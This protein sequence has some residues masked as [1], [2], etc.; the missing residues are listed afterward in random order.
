LADQR[1][2]LASLLRRL[3]AVVE[4]S[5]SRELD[6]LLRGERELRVVVGSRNGRSE[7]SLPGL[8]WSHKEFTAIASRL[9]ELATR[10]AGRDLLD[11][12]LPTRASLE[13]FARFLDLPVQRTD[14]IELLREKIIESAIGSRLRSEA[15]QGRKS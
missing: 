10:E 12:A 5:S 7:R 13:R 14:T 6:A 2:M 11:G 1:K 4:Q 15:V 9:S 3:A 8:G